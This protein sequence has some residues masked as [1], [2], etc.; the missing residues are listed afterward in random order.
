VLH[1]FSTNDYP[2]PRQTAEQAET[3]ARLAETA[4]HLEAARKEVDQLGERL[5]D[6]EAKVASLVAAQEMSRSKV[7]LFVGQPPAS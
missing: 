7:C 1:W 3:S 4:A 6:E 2:L 5:K